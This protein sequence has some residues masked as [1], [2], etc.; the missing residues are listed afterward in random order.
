MISYVQ[1]HFQVDYSRR[2]PTTGENALSYSNCDFTF[3]SQLLIFIGAEKFWIQIMDFTSLPKPAPLQ[4]P[5][6]SHIYWS[7]NPFPPWFTLVCF[8]NKKICWVS[9]SWYIYTIM[10][11]GA[12]IFFLEIYLFPSP[13][14]IFL[15]KQRQ[16]YILMLFFCKK[17]Q[18]S[19]SILLE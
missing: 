3:G 10:Y 16:N 13:K 7:I 6:P 12:F 4:S 9:V 15:A 18:A 5:L 8:C 17:N 19:Q 14:Y 1:V 2:L 11:F